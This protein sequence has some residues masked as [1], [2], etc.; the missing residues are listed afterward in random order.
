VDCGLWIVDLVPGAQSQS[1][2]HNQ[3]S[4]IS[5]PQS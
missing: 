3:Q 4:T 1:A 5:N 2:I